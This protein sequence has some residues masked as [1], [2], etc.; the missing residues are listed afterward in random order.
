[1]TG[2]HP[3]GRFDWERALRRSDLPKLR[4]LVAFTL[5]TYA[6]PD[7]T[8]ARP[9]LTEL[10]DACSMPY[11]TVKAH[12]KALRD[13]G[14]LDR[15]V[16]GSSLGRRAMADEHHLTV[17]IHSSLVSPDRGEHSSLV[18]GTQLTSEPEQGSLVSPHQIRD[19]TKTKQIRV[20]SPPTDI[21]DGVVIAALRERTGKTITPEHARAV[22]RQ[23][24][25]GR[26]VRNRGAYVRS[27]IDRDPNPERFLPTPGPPPY[28]HPTEEG[29]R[30]HA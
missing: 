15:T 17:P 25:A 4:K 6:D 28:R 3:A 29:T 24:L 14:W 1:M 23:I 30:A 2:A 7:G 16:R 5:A 22:A 18:S 10:A 13:A 26:H 12:L 27:A 19:Q 9:G 20:G 8:S 21:A 11:S